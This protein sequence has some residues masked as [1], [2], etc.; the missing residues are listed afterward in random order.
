M[1]NEE[2][3]Q[4]HNV[5]LNDNN[6]D[7]TSI[8]ETIN[9]LPDKVYIKLQ[10]KNVEPTTEK[11]EIVPDEGYTGL[12]KVTVEGVQG[13][14]LE[15]MPS[16]ENQNF[17]GIYT[18]VDVVG[19]ENLLPENI[20]KGTSIFGVEGNASVADFKITNGAY[21]FYNGYRTDYLQEFLN[22][23]EKIKSA[24]YMFYKCSNLPE[25][26]VSNLDT[27][28]VTDMSY[29]FYQCSNV[30]E[31]DV[32]NFDTSKVANMSYMFYKCSNLLEIDVSNFDTSNVTNMTY[33]FY[34]CSN[35][36][37]IDVSNFDTSKV[38]DM[39]SMFYG[40]N[41]VEE[42]DL[43]NWDMGKVTN[44]ATMFAYSTNVC[45]YNSFKS[46]YNL[47]KAYTQKTNNYTYYRMDLTRPLLRA[48]HDMIIDV[49]NNG[50]Y[51]LNLS[52]NVANGG[53]LYTQKLI[54]GSSNLAKITPEELAIATNKRLD[55]KLIM[56]CINIQNMI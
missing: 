39:G 30:P 43:S 35:V 2:I 14:N 12:E 9:N 37:E 25:I 16:A 24:Y 21:L 36:P 27:S 31:I 19:D 29:M 42:L 20:K 56:H 44:V 33:M 49:I 5:R 11:Q 50:I 13:D 54:L 18:N 23:C 46:F 26:D 6:T 17:K 8:L 40:I 53:T 28:E 4:Q 45:K 1:S 48:T 32:S 34:G 10:E 47:G 55:G 3:L 22:I 41:N 52:Y 15:V 7:L 38:T 51:D